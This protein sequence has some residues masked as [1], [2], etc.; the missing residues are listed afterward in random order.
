[1]DLRTYF[2]QTKPAE[3]KAFA[4]K[5]GVHIDYLYHCSRGER[6]PGAKLCRLIVELDS[7]FTLAELRPDIWGNGIDRIAAI[8]DTQQNAGGTTSRKTKEMRAA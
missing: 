1:M 7:R 6:K 4:D 5:L 2:Q 3:R 8:D